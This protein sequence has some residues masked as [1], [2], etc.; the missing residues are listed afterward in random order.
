MQN[1]R[2]HLF[3]CLSLAAFGSIAARHASAQAW[4]DRPI[5]IIVPFGAGSATDLMARLLGHG[6]LAAFG[7]PVVVENRAGAGGTIG[8]EYIARAAADGYTLGAATAGTFAIAPQLYSRI[9]YDPLGDFEPLVLAG[10]APQ[11]FVVA[12]NSPI[13]SIADLIQAARAAPGTLFYG[14][15]GNGSTQHLAIEML[16]NIAGVRMTHVPYRTASLALSDI[17][18]GQIALTADTLP[19][20]MELVRSGRLRPLGVTSSERSPFFPDVPTVL[21]QGVPGYQSTGWV[22][23]VTPK[24]VPP[25]ILQRLET[26]MLGIIGTPAFQERMAASAFPPSFLGREQ[27][28]GFISTEVAKWRGVVEAAGIGKLD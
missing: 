5:R 28:T 13:H 17:M 11:M 22:G 21:E 23:F 26:T 24:G 18:S 19:S 1:S 9:G 14:S 20:V 7:Q 16:C 15:G 27:F 3:Q 8:T 2:R 4:P 12:A 25:E 6:M 10:A